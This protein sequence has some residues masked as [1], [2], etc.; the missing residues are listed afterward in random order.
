[1][2]K[3]TYD[4]DGPYEKDIVNL[5]EP[6]I[7]KRVH[8]YQKAD[9][10]LFSKIRRKGYQIMLI[11]FGQE[12]DQNV[13]NQM[14]IQLVIGRANDWNYNKIEAFYQKFIYVM[15]EKYKNLILVLAC[16][17]KEEKKHMKQKIKGRIEILSY[18]KDPFEWNERMKN[19]IESILEL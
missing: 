9:Q 5:S 12:N 8:Y 11:D 19:E 6:Y 14:D 13:F 7:F 3:R 1:M 16:G 10:E 15:E 18:H 4:G 17:T 2:I